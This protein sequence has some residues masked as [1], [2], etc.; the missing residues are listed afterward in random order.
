MKLLK[1]LRSFFKFYPSS[2]SK[3]TLIEQFE[4]HSIALSGPDTIVMEQAL[5]KVKPY[6]NDEA[7]GSIARACVYPRI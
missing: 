1:L 3:Q 7:F 4:L 5:E 6:F 2:A